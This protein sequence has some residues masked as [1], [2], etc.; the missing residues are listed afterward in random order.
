MRALV[1]ACSSADE[2]GG[3]GNGLRREGWNVVAT[4]PVDG[5]EV[6]DGDTSTN[7]GGSWIVLASRQDIQEA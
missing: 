7:I 6:R 5:A 4:G 1:I 2:A 3:I